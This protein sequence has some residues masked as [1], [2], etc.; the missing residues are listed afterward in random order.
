M[1]WRVAGVKVVNECEGIKVQAKANQRGVVG[2]EH[3]ISEA[4]SLPSRNRTRIKDSDV[5]IKASK[6]IQGLRVSTQH[7]AIFSQIIFSICRL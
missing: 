1:I 3:A 5:V 4:V 6:A 7:F 2:I